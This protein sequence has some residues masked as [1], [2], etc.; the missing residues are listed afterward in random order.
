MRETINGSHPRFVE[1]KTLFIT[2]TNH[3]IRK[4]Q[5]TAVFFH[6]VNCYLDEAMNV[7]CDKEN[8]DKANK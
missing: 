3:Y 5:G 4:D 2:T 1:K 8:M 7:L 6:R